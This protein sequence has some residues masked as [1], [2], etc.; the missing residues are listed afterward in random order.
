MEFQLRDKI[1]NQ[2]R[3]TEKHFGGMSVVYIVLDEFSQ[4][5][6]AVKTLKEE[7][8][9]DRTAISRFSAEART[10][11]NLGR[12]ENI[13]EAIIYRE[14]EGQPFLFLEYIEGANLQVLIDIERQLFPPQLTRFMLRS[15]RR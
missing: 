11:M 6:F 8:L 3:V 10:W 1:D 13:V 12:H 9:E 15:A 4:R 7:L 14:I 2:Y 5:R